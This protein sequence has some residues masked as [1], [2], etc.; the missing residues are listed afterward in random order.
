[1]R[2]SADWPGTSSRPKPIAFADSSTMGSWIVLAWL[3]SVYRDHGYSPAAA[4]L[5]LSMSAV[6]QIP[7]TLLLPSLATRVHD[8][9]LLAAGATLLT[10]AGLAGVLFAP[11][12]VPYVWMLVLG[13]GQGATFAIGLTLFVVRTAGQD[14]VRS[15]TG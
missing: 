15:W 9:R 6:V 3:P 8:Q 11:T 14:P 4:G 1:M 5:L 2:T 12:T 13:V 10:A 7:V